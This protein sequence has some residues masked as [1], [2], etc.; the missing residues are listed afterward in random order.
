[1]GIG[2]DG[3]AITATQPTISYTDTSHQDSNETELPPPESSAHTDFN[4]AE[5]HPAIHF[6]ATTSPIKNTGDTVKK[7]PPRP[8]RQVLRKKIA[9]K[10]TSDARVIS[11][12]R[13]NSPLLGLPPEVLTSILSYVVG[14]KLI[15]VRYYKHEHFN[16]G[17]AKQH[18]LWNPSVP[19][20]FRHC[21]CL[22]K[23]SEDTAYEHSRFGS[24]SVPQKYDPE[25]YVESF[26]DRHAALR[27]P[28]FLP[29]DFQNIA[30]SPSPLSSSL[31]AV[32]RQIYELANHLLYATNTFSFNDA[33]SVYAFMKSLHWAQKRKITKLH[34]CIPW[35]SVP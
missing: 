31:L 22:A 19:H 35:N 3:Q 30:P 13:E 16:E 25:Y 2:L 9:V 4:P 34:L 26:M 29:T 8:K 27:R 21:V 6:Q 28:A 15:H 18:K 33:I 17:C 12:N 1:M 24:P 11:L 7:A 23:T 20:V 14:D 32:S 10:K 5:Y